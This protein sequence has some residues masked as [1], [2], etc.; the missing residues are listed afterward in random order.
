MCSQGFQRS[1]KALTVWSSRG[2]WPVCASVRGFLYPPSNGRCWRTRLCTQSTPQCQTTLLPAP[3]SWKA[4][5]TAL[6]SVSAATQ[7][8]KCMKHSQPKKS[9]LNLAVTS[10]S[11]T[12]DRCLIKQLLFKLF[13]IVQKHICMFSLFPSDCRSTL[14]I[15]C[16]MAWNYHCLFDRCFSLNCRFLFGKKMPPVFIPFI[17]LH[18]LFVDNIYTYTTLNL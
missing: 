2:S 16:Q 1:S 17:Y 8:G 12:F 18:I 11:A 5:M 4:E 14:R 6:S 3:S 15:I 7:M 9:H 10:A 13:I